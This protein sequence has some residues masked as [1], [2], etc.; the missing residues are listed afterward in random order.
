MK[1]ELYT[2]ITVQIGKDEYIEVQARELTKKEEANFQK[3]LKSIIDSSEKASRLDRK[4]KNIERKLGFVTDPAKAVKLIDELDDKQ[5]QA[6]ELSSEFSDKGIAKLNQLYEE[7][8]S[9]VISGTGKDRL[10]EIA[11][12]RGFKLLLSKID[13]EKAKTDSEGNLP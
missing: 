4:I 9:L 3:K 1:I 2:D 6:E 8:F 7:K 12:I 11:E 13:E 10:R 5:D